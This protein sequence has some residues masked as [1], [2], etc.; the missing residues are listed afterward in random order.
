MFTGG[1]LAASPRLPPP[2][3]RRGRPARRA[4]HHRGGQRDHGGRARLGARVVTGRNHLVL[5]RAV[6]R[7]RRVALGTRP[8]R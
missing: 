7:E 6:P 2:R 1:T 4:G 5:E 3:L 8:T